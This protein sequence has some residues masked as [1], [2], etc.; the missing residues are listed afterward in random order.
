MMVIV[1]FIMM[2]LMLANF[3]SVLRWFL[4]GSEHADCILTER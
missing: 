3:V 2:L 1:T 4:G